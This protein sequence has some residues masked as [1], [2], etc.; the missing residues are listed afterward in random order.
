MEA[1]WKTLMVSTASYANVSTRDVYGNRT[2]GT[3]VSFKCH[4]K[5]AR[6]EQGTAEGSIVNFAGT[7]Y[8]DGVYDVQKNAVLL[9]P[10]GT[11][12]KIKDIQTFYDEKGSH[13]TTISFE[14]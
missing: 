7:L 8:M 9:L 11:S 13:H 12:P 5:T 4:I 2:A 10:D 1:Q 14:G 6:V 3:P